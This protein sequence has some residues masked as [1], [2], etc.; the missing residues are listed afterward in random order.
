ME[1]LLVDDHKLF[2]DGLTLL[3]KKLASDV[4]IV[5]AGNGQE[6]KALFNDKE[7]DLAIFDYSLPDCTGLELLQTLKQLAAATPVVIILGHE[8]PAIIRNCLNQGASGYLPMTLDPEEISDALQLVLN[9]AIYVPPFILKSLQEN[10]QDNHSDLAKLAEVARNIIN[11]SDW[12]LR[13]NHS[14]KAIDDSDS[15]AIRVFNKALD[16]RKISWQVL[17][18]HNSSMNYLIFQS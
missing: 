2:S 5:Q 4:S 18:R 1:L 16:P 15:K 10:P 13:A 17:C 12:S 11:N 6:A 9:G 7:Y 8:E 3:L 14:S